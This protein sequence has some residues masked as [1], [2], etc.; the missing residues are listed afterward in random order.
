MPELP[1][2]EVCRRNLQRW[3][4]GQRLTAV[5]LLDPR[6]IRSRPSTRPSDGHPRAEAETHQWIQ[7][8]AGTPTRHGKRIGWNFGD[9]GVL[10]HLGMTGNWHRQSDPP[11]FAKLGLHF[12]SCNLWFTDLRRFGCLWPLPVS[13][14]EME[15]Q[16]GHGPDALHNPPDASTLAQSFQTRKP[17]KVALLDQHR[18][19]GIGNIL[20]AEALW[21]A[22]IHPSAPANT[23]HS[24]QWARLS[25]SL[26]SIVLDT[27]EAEDGNTITYINEGGSNPFSVY[28]RAQMPC[29]RCEHPIHKMVQAGRTTFFCPTC[30]PS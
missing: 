6:C 27:I 25:E 4:S 28:A 23:L 13:S 3:A 11:R 16:K 12:E 18:L 24:S 8:L 19:A 15:L 10:I 2:V 26:L 9:H 29:P 17:I 30:Q 20:A 22:Q 1:E 5:T 21:R 14:I 7:Q